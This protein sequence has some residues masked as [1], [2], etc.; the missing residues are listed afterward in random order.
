MAFLFGLVVGMLIMIVLVAFMPI[1]AI[2]DYFSW[3]DKFRGLFGMMTPRN[4]TCT[5]P[6]EESTTDSPSPA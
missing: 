1:K 3:T 5:K 6:E 2:N 4:I